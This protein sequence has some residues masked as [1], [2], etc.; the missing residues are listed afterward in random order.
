MAKYKRHTYLIKTGLQLRYMGILIA[1]MLTV[2][3][4]V[5][6]IIYHTS[7]KQIVNTPDLS[8]DKLYLIFESVNSQLVWWILAFI[9][10]IAIISIFVSHKIAGPVYRLE[11]STKLIAS[12]DLT[13]KVHLR[14]GDELGDLQDA[15]NTMSESL[16]KMVYKDREIIERLAKTGENLQKKVDDKNLNKESLEEI[17]YELNSIIEELK[18]V[19]SGFKLLETQEENKEEQKE[20]KEDTV[21]EENKNQEESA[22]NKEN[23]VQEEEK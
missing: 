22:E 20:N 2:A 12:G 1:C 9:V 3:M 8:L 4:G 7:W 10:I 16:S 15:F 21:Q 6:W 23:T 19:T 5:G 14:Q 13:H 11:E 17:A 18:L